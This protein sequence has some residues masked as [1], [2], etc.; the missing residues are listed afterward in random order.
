MIGAMCNELVDYT[1]SNCTTCTLDDTLLA[2]S[3]FP[4]S[5]SDD[6]EPSK[7]TITLH[8]FLFPLP[9]WHREVHNLFAILQAH[10]DNKPLQLQCSWLLYRVHAICN[11]IPFLNPI[12]HWVNPM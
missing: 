4:S 7:S 3:T 12:F 6:D 8:D 2:S 10:R 9:P 11:D 1:C 5:S